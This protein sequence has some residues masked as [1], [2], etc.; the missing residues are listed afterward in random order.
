MDTFMATV[1]GETWPPFIA[2]GILVSHND[3]KPVLLEDIRG[4]VAI[5]VTV[6]FY[7]TN[8]AR[9]MGGSFFRDGGRWEFHTESNKQGIIMFEMLSKPLYDLY[10]K[11]EVQIDFQSDAEIQDFYRQMGMSVYSG[12]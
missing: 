10:F 4:D 1:I 5:N 3:E 8:R 9:R 6:D 12:G 2:I 7:D 11:G